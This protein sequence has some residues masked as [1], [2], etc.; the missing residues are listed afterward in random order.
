M[1]MDQ[2]SDISGF[3]KAY[4]TTRPALPGGGWLQELR[5]IA[6]TRFMSLGLPGRKLE[7]W[8]YADLKALRKTPFQ[9]VTKAPE[10]DIAAIE[11][12]AIAGLDAPRL[13]F[14]NGRFSR[15]LSRLHTLPADLAPKSLRDVL[16]LGGGSIR[17]LVMDLRDGDAFDQLNTA[18]MSEG[19][20]IEVPEGMQVK[21]PIEIVYLVTDADNGA[22]HL[23][24]VIRLGQGA[25]LTV[26]E[27]FAGDDSRFF[28]NQI[29]QTTLADGADLTLL[30]R[31]HE[32]SGT[33]H[34]S[35]T[36]AT[37]GKAR[38]QM[39]SIASGSASARH[40]LRA[41]VTTEGGHVGYEGIQLARAGQV[42]DTLTFMDHA[43]PSCTSTQTY[44]AV[45]A[46]QSKAAFQ[47]KVLVRR[48]AQH[49]DARQKADSLLLDRAAEASTKPEL[50]IYADDVQCA[51]GATVGELDADQVF[52][53]MA[54]GLAPDEA[55][56][57]LVEAFV[58]E[59][60]G[61]IANEP[62]RDAFLA[63]ARNW[64]TS[65]N[66]AMDAPKEG[67]Q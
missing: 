46:G 34:V 60:C 35:R 57:L 12:A 5:H 31:Q 26:V 27:S 4:D 45:L 6:M 28:T 19:V 2:S 67:D 24:N 62:V 36:Y 21:T 53:L 48:D 39:A 61:N 56:A 7:S 8:R 49:T 65:A 66:S 33:V 17:D 54:R 55:R 38:F 64:L 32:G 22:A 10:A 44:R 25:S 14:V 11:K 47:G 13:V 30:R 15:P 1:M 40:E 50:E 20:V 58:A 16:M 51:H 23:R 42:L 41:D 3:Q 59:L 52:Y 63:D 37:L 18:M 43:V 9:P 29:T